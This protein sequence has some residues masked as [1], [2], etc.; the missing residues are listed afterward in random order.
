MTEQPTTHSTTRVSGLTASL[1]GVAGAVA[2]EA[3]VVSAERTGQ[4]KLLAARDLRKL[5][6]EDAALTTDLTRVTTALAG[7]DKAST[8]WQKRLADA[9][10]VWQA[11][12]AAFATLH[13]GAG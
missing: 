5:A 9:T 1:S 13:P 8:A 2:R 4:A 7:Q 6:G 12:L 10:K 11:S 3:R